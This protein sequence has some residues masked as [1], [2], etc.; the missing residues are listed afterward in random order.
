MSRTVE[1]SVTLEFDDATASVD[2]V[3]ICPSTFAALADQ[4]DYLSISLCMRHRHRRHSSQQISQV[5]KPAI[6]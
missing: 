6:H 5:L 3:Q 2:V 4:L 1:L